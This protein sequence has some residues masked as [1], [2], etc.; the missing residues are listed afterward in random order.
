MR[1]DTCAHKKTPKFM[2]EQNVR[3][4]DKMLLIVRIHNTCLL[5]LR[6]HTPLVSV[7]QELLCV[8]QW[9]GDDFLQRS[10]RCFTSV[11][12]EH[13]GANS[14]QAKCSWKKD[15]NDHANLP[16]RAP[17]SFCFF[18]SIVRSLSSCAFLY[19]YSRLSLTSRRSYA[20]ITPN[21]SK[22]R[23]LNIMTLPCKMTFATISEHVYTSHTT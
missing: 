7:A 15:L 6:R 18:S 5:P 12:S 22:D 16:S 23:P 21:Y 10:K 19:R 8:S 17:F 4:T 3:K 13:F 1:A 11:W 20:N 2:S 9:E 14:G